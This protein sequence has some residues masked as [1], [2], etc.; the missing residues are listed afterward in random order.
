MSML[1]YAEKVSSLS[2]HETND[3]R[4]R[5][6]EKRKVDAFSGFSFSPRQD[7]RTLVMDTG[8]SHAHSQLSKA[9][10]DIISCKYFQTLLQTY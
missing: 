10:D 8:T 4:A 1:L 9:I 7:S 3:S 2:P 5:V 6:S